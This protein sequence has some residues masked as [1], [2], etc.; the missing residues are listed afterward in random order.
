MINPGL[1]LILKRVSLG[2]KWW[3]EAHFL[4][5]HLYNIAL[6]LKLMCFLSS[7]SS[8]PLASF[9]LPSFFLPFLSY[10][11]LNLF[12]FLN[13]LSVLRLSSLFTLITKLMQA[14]VRFK[15]RNRWNIYFF[16]QALLCLDWKVFFLKHCKM[17]TVYNFQSQHRPNASLKKKNGAT[18]S[19]IIPKI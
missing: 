19:P 15:G 6:T 17:F 11:Y 3:N 14:E 10:S 9:L 5:E 7:P 1:L 4:T 12:N 13:L 18:I 16:S 8:A 2:A